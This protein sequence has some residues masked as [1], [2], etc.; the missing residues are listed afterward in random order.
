MTHPILVTG[1]TG[2][3]GR[4]VLK[5]LVAKGAAVRAFV[6]SV[7]KGD[8]LKGPNV[9]IAIGDLD[10]PDTLDSAMTGIDKVFLLSPGDPRQVELQG[11]AVRAAQRAGVKYMVKLAALGVA[12]ESPFALARWHAQT[13]KQ[14]E[15]SGMAYT[16]LHPHSFMQNFLGMAPM[17]AEGNLYAPMKDGRISLVD[18]RDIAAVAAATLTEPGHEGKTYDITGPE[19]LSYA[20]IAEKLSE[21]IGKKVTYVDISPEVARKNMLDMG[22]PEWLADDFKVLYEVFSAGYAAEVS[23][24]VAEVANKEP[25]TFG[26][27]AQDYAGVFKGN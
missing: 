9:E 27:F 2:T 26:Q 11:N 20:D 10:Q 6:R 12:P 14:I 24:V 7:E 1:A 8:A 18:A 16:H 25:I 13:E 5:Q 3:V 23:P 17:I 21:V 4:E 22:F 19:A 15:E